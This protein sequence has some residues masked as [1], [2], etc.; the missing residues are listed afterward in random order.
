MV[1]RAVVEAE[2]NGNGK[3]GGGGVVQF[4]RVEAGVKGEVAERGVRELAFRKMAWWL[5]ESCE[6]GSVSPEPLLLSRSSSSSKR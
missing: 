4:C 2:R 5:E 3:G 6:G 1:L